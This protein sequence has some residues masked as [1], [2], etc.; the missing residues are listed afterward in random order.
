MGKNRATDI[1]IELRPKDPKGAK[2]VL[3]L[4]DPRLFTG[5]NKLH[6]VMDTQT[7]HWYLKYDSGILPE[8]LKQRFTGWTP[9]LNFIKQY[10]AKRGI[11]IVNIQD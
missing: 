10:Y 11:E 6:A 7:T 9:L 1:I 2:N 3:G 4:T 5:E 8:V